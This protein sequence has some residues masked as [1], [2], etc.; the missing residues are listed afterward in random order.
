MASSAYSPECV[1][2]KFSEIR[3]CQVVPR[4]SVRYP[5]VNSDVCSGALFIVAPKAPIRLWR[6]L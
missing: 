2:G 3:W 1:E 6:F 5:L 4:P